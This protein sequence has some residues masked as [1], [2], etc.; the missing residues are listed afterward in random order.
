VD[1][2][3][4]A[5]TLGI[6][7]YVLDME[8]EFRREVIAPFAAAYRAGRTPV[9]CAD[10][11]AGPKFRHLLAR[12][13]DLGVERLATGHYARIACDPRSGGRRLLAATD[14]R[15]DQS[16][17][18]H[19]LTQDQ[20][21]RL[22]FPVGDRTKIEVRALAA[23]RGLPNAAKPDSQDLCFVP[24]G[25]YLAIVRREGDAGPAGEIVSTAGESLGRHDGIAAFTIG[26]RRGLGL[27]S[28][29]SWYVVD[30][31]PENGRV[32]VGGA[33]E[34]ARATLCAD[35][36]SWIAGAPPGA[37]FAATARIRSSHAGA[38]CRVRTLH[39]DRI[40]VRFDAPQRAVTPGQAVV[41][42]DGDAVLGGGTIARP[43]RPRARRFDS[44]ANAMLESRAEG[45]A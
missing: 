36:V 33:H 38:P 7:F 41:L 42:Y 22:V 37:S 35:G 3:A 17:F 5:E 18:L 45:R 30:I 16:Y 27:S 24:D 23:A 32:T 14:R 2:R 44:R 43:A 15:R 1:A 31:D 4:V 20:L 13:R 10:C 29:R 34:Q 9:P 28:H 6:P 40:A 39:G 19:A 25:G 8:E 11:N 26:Q 12:A 21:D